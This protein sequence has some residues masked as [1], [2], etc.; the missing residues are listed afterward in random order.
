MIS[1]GVFFL[2]NLN[3]C[4]CCRVGGSYIYDSRVTQLF[5]GVA[6]NCVRQIE[7]FAGAVGSHGE[8]ISLGAGGISLE[9][10][11]EGFSVVVCDI[12]ALDE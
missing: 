12:D 1:Y 4:V 9:M 7:A 5:P 2:Y 11:E 3:K 10:G 6:V 8:F